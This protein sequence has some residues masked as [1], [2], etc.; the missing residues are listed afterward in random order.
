MPTMSSSDAA[1]DA[2]RRL[3]D[4]LYNPAPAA[5]FACFGAHTMDAI[6]QLADIFA[7]TG[8]PTPTPTPPPRLTPATIQL[9]LLHSDS[10]P[11]APPRVPP[12]VPSCRL[13]RPPPVP[14]PRVDPPVHN[15]PHRYPLC[16]RAQANHTVE[17][18][19]EGAIAFQG[20][21]DPATGKF[22]GSRS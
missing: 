10:N 1:T 6:R 19:G 17:T 11:Q 7:A 4:S 5:P 18:V 8:A 21:L 2:S 20:V 16:S 3:V 22:R 14:P 13:P 12:T 9:P 15:P